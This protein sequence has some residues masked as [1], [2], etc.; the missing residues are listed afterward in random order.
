MVS[1]IVR[2]SCVS[3]LVASITYGSSFAQDVSPPIVVNNRPDQQVDELLRA[4]VYGL[5]V[6]IGSD[7]IKGDFF[8]G[9]ASFEF[10]KTAVI[11]SAYRI[12]EVQRALKRSGKRKEDV[13]VADLKTIL[14][15]AKF[16]ERY[17]TKGSRAV[18]KRSVVAMTDRLNVAN[19][20]RYVH[21][22][23]FGA[24]PRTVN[25]YDAIGINPV[26][27]VGMVDAGV[28]EPIQFKSGDK[29]GQGGAMKKLS[30]EQFFQIKEQ[31]KAPF[32]SMYH[33]NSLL[34]S[35]S[36]R[37]RS[38]QLSRVINGA[39]KFSKLEKALLV[40]LGE[41]TFGRPEIFTAQEK[42]L[43]LSS[44]TAAR[45]DVYWVELFVSFRDIFADSLTQMAFH[46]SI[47]DTYVALALVPD[48]YG[49]DVEVGKKLATPS[50]DVEFG[51]KSISVGEF[52]SRSVSFNYLRP[53]I[54]SQGPG[55]SRFDWIMRDEAVISGAHKFVAIIGVPRGENKLPLALSAHVVTKEFIVANQIAGTRVHGREITLK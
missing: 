11:E 20:F 37:Q 30:D 6:L 5:R 26:G 1:R 29:V 34:S 25:V 21:R 9:S 3:F 33:G 39:K 50:I 40:E 35:M 54:V 15:T 23:K 7:P 48:R 28:I 49:V 43:V 27:I 42:N 18:W 8:A 44:N 38:A 36:V 46:V 52:Y 17:L 10:S 19:G 32:L 22:F 45:F 31:Y 2:I 16:S 4:K 24:R 41:I 55:E 53:T 14:N 12:P 51:G 13:T 47:P